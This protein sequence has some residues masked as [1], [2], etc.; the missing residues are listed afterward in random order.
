MK[1]TI[2]N[3]NPAG[4][5]SAFD[6]YLSA[7]QVELEGGGHLVTRLDL[8]DMDLKHCTGCW[9]CW[10]KTP[11]E[12]VTR[13]DGAV[14]RR[15]VL[16]ADV[17]LHASPLIM[18]YPS[19][20]TKKVMD[21]T[22]PII[23]PYMAIV[24]SEFH[25]TARY[26][27]YPRLGLL[28]AREEG[29]DEADL[30]IVS[31]LFCR[32]ALNMKTELSFMKDTTGTNPAELAA[33]ITRPVQPPLM[34]QT[35]PQ[36]RP[37]VKITPPRQITV[38]NGSPRGAR[39]N[40]AI[41]M[42]EFARGFTSVD[43]NRVETF[44]L[45]HLKDHET[46]AKA[47]GEAETVW[48]GFPLYTDAMPGIVKVF[49]EALAPFV[50]RKDNPSMGFL[51]QSGFPEGL[52]SRY[53]ERY[54]EKLAG[55]LGSPY[56]GTMVKGNGEGTRLMPDSMN[57]ALFEGLN[58]LG[59]SLAENG[60]LDSALLKKLASPERM[61]SI[62]MPMVQAAVRLGLANTYWNGLLKENKALGQ[63]G[64]RPYEMGRE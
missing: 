2:L 55:R 16:Q 33:Q 23:H 4:Q 62:I 48:L 38:F 47:F 42:R 60:S 26:D 56:L 43:G 30:S 18:G 14:M 17:V 13:D 61:P 8:R 9:G 41:M 1:I 52:H 7:L 6:E 24:N 29:S 53:V 44:D 59:R 63:V 11:G 27:H 5:T 49:I 64:A 57:R 22:I 15:A 37:G 3:G 35:E 39:G 19:A 31:D 46:F 12:C 51:V 32:T 20:L 21:K 50:G 10:V 34:I 54:L 25:H 58:G 28:V 45:V 36:A 40:T